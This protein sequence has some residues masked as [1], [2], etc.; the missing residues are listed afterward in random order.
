MAFHAK[1]F[2]RVLRELRKAR[3]LSQEQLG[4]R[5]NVHR[6]YIGKV[7][8]GEKDVSLRTAGKLAEALGMRLSLILTEFENRGGKGP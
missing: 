5:A 8:R 4:D 7:E 1:R 6:T 2:G 3:S